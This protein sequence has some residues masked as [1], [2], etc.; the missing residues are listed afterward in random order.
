MLHGRA[1]RPPEPALATDSLATPPPLGRP[2]RPVPYL[3]GIEFRFFDDPDALADAY[4]AGGLDA[5]SGLPPA[6]GRDAR[7]DAGQ[8][9]AALSGCRP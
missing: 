9:L 4:R 8:P 5:A 2:T 3:P 1:R 7:R 6:M